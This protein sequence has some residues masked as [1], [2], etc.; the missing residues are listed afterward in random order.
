M[1][2]QSASVVVMRRL[3]QLGFNGTFEVIYNDNIAGKLNTLLPGFN[4][5]EK[6]WQTLEEF[7]IR[8]ISESS[9]KELS[10]LSL[11]DIALTGADD[12]RK[13]MTPEKMFAK[14]YL[15]MEP[16]GWGAS[17]LLQA[18]QNEPKVIPG[19]QNLGYIYDVD[20]SPG[21]IEKNILSIEE[22]LEFAEKAQG[23]R[24]LLN[25]EGIFGAIY[26]VGLIPNMPERIK[27]WTQGIQM[28]ERSLKFSQPIVLPIISPLN[29]FEMKTLKRN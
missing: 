25:S 23:L 29:E 24:A 14:N 27:I 16:L 18:G 17:F 8:A 9:F 15:L 19:L 10:N 13:H 28:A 2:H 20:S 5:Q 11:V 26:G 4:P 7:K 22:N 1:G 6:N 12:N 3:R 21:A